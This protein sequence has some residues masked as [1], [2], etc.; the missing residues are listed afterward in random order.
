MAKAH[1][2]SLLNRT[3]G[4]IGDL[5]YRKYGN[6]TVVSKAPDF[7]RRKLSIAQEAS[8]D[9]FR[10]AMNWARKAREDPEIWA[11]YSKKRKGMQTLFNVAVR[12]FMS[13]PRIE[14]IRA[15]SY[16]GNPGDVITIEA[17]DNYK[18]T[19]VIISIVNA[20][21]QEIE[22]GIGVQNPFELFEWNFEAKETNPFWAGGRIEVVVRDLP[23]NTVKSV[24]ELDPDTSA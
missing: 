7:T 19:G 12:D 2:N 20:R 11:F 17:R 22:C 15:G 24:L 9:R 4:R 23:G 21:K 18:V 5:V 8:N 6:K 16:H 10:E 1:L 14:K 13:L 3:F